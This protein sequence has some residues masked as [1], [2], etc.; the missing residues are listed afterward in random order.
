MPYM[1]T[2]TSCTCVYASLGLAI[3]SVSSKCMQ[4][5]TYV[6][7]I[8]HYVVIGWLQGCASLASSK[9]IRYM[10]QQEW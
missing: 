9:C 3:V 2:N 8:W 4:L 6:G 1:M 10:L 5:Y 7:A